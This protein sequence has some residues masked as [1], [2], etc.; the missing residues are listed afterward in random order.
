MTSTCDI[1]K[2]VTIMIDI[3]LKIQTLLDVKPEAMRARHTNLE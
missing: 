3:I 1:N 2:L